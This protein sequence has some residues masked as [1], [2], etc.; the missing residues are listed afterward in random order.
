MA[1]LERQA[2]NEVTLTPSLQ[3][4]SVPW[5]SLGRDPIESPTESVGAVMKAGF[6]H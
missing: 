3:G 5:R 1:Q 6:E 2:T 4:P